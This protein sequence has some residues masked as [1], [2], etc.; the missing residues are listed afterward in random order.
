M[1]LSDD[2][3]WRIEIESWPKLAEV[4]GS[5][6]MPGGK[7]GFYTQEE[8][9]QIVAY[10][11]ARHIEVIPEIDVP[12]HSSAAIA[13]YPELGCGST[14]TVCTTSPVV[15]D[16][17]N[18]VIG[19]I[20]PMSNSDLFHIGGDE[21]ISGQPYIDF[22]K[23]IEGFVID[24][25][26]RMVGWSPVP[27]AGLDA[28]SVH[29]YWRDQSYEMTPEWFAGGN[30]VILSPTSKVYL[31]YP[32]PQHNAVT[33][34]D[35]DPSRVIDDYR[36]ASL[37][38]Y[39]LRDEDILGIEGPAWGENNSGG[40]VD[41]EHKVFP[42][43][44][45]ILDL[46]WSPQEKTTDPRSFLQRLAVQGSRWQFAGTN[47]WPDPLVEWTTTAA[48]T[49]HSIPQESL[50]ISGS[51]ATVASPTHRVEEL[52]ATIDWGD[53]TSTAGTMSGS[54]ASGKRGNSLYEVIGEHTYA[55]YGK[56]SGTV[57]VTASDGQSW[58][59]HFMVTTSG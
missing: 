36:G 3:G 19:E 7:S 21:S 30:D 58:T 14:T 33:T 11:D 38:S 5:R 39:G 23:K 41:V 12:G 18:D 59:T 8:F 55:E 45:S 27:M 25:G 48:G 32:Y 28:S 51:V 29:H 24:H 46:A 6:S 49:V 56:W 42:R 2:Q 50:A 13:A 22:I 15:D 52:S 57:T 1:H 10:A 44:A 16:F 34:Y 37:Q 35:W 20:A 53:G 31:D 17:L 4:G 9:A 26:K 47:F 54:S 43:L 40:I